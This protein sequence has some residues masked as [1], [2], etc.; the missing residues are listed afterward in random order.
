M[1]RFSLA[2]CRFLREIR[3]LLSTVAAGGLL[4]YR[5]GLALGWSGIRAAY[6]TFRGV[7]TTKAQGCPGDQ[8]YTTGRKGYRGPQA[9]FFQGLTVF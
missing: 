8:T 2:P 6:A 5:L 4:E 7:C 3:D 9:G 1:R